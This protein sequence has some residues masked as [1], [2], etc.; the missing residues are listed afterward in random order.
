M[1]PEMKQLRDKL[2]GLKLDGM[3]VSNPANVRYLTG[4]DAEGYLLITPKENVFITDGRF[5]E[6]VNN[7]LTIDSEIVCVEGKTLTSYDHKSYFEECENIGFEERYVTYE[8][9]KNYLQTYQVN[10]VETEGIIESQRIVKEEY[11]I[12]KIKKACEITDKAFDATI[13]NL[14]KGMTEKEV[15]CLLNYQMVKFGAEGF[16]FETIV[17]SGPNSSMPHAVPTDRVIEENDIVLFDF[18]AKFGGYC[19]DCSRTIF[20]GS[21]TEKQKK[22]YEFVLEEQQKAIDNFKEGTNLKTI[23]KNREMDYK[24][25]NLRLIHALGHGVGLEIHE[26]PFLRSTV[27]CNLKKDSVIAIEPGVYFPGEFG[28][29]IEDTCRVTKEKSEPLTQSKK[30][31]KIVKLK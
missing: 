31:L 7:E 1:N 14:R 5:I 9:Y 25:E 11:E 15:A 26:E 30:D 16:A 24:L 13:N 17:A 6:Q 23:V 18:G 22:Y 10:L 27:D 29:R 8:N 20:I 12:E 3:I 28:I 19:S 2:K 4:L 21:V